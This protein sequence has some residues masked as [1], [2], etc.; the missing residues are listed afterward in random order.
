MTIEDLQ[1]LA[2]AATAAEV[3]LE[4]IDEHTVRVLVYWIEAYR[5]APYGSD[6]I[7]KEVT[8]VMGV[9]ERKGYRHA[10]YEG[11]K[12]LGKCGGTTDFAMAL[13]E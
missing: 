4:A 5:H 10:Y 2:A 1:S 11:R 3:E 6:T 8:A 9:L 12:D 13:D 7:I